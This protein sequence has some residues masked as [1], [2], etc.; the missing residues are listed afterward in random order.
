MQPLPAAQHLP[1]PQQQRTRDR[2]QKTPRAPSARAFSSPPSLSTCSSTNSTSPPLPDHLGARAMAACRDTWLL[3]LPPS[4]RP[5]PSYRS[6]PALS[7]LCKKRGCNTT[8]MCMRRCFFAICG[9]SKTK[10][11]NVGVE[12]SRPFEEGMVRLIE[13]RDRSIKCLLRSGGLSL[14][15]CKAPKPCSRERVIQTI[16]AYTYMAPLG[17]LHWS[18]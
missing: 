12:S 10:E 11:L 3:L 1:P 17:L 16:A 18:S 2:A 14:L 8:A 4:L 6:E 5:A 13:C 15:V 9:P 7:L